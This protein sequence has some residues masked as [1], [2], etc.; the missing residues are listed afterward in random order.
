MHRNLYDA[1]ALELF[2]LPSFRRTHLSA[3]FVKGLLQC[4]SHIFYAIHNAMPIKVTLVH[5]RPPIPKA[6]LYAQLVSVCVN[7][8]SFV[9]TFY[10]AFQHPISLNKII[11]V[12]GSTLQS[13]LHFGKQQIVPKI[14][15][16][17]FSLAILHSS[18]NR[19]LLDVHMVWDTHHISSVERK[20]SEKSNDLAKMT[21]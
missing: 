2:V 4:I 12:F 15:K 13:Q 16:F 10:Q 7:H 19:N 18:V 1:N 17:D 5:F 20:L 11:V 21:C 8:H 6:N 14:E 9:I 3:R